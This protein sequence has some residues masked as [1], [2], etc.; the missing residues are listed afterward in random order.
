[1]KPS[2]ARVA[3]H[4]LRARTSPIRKA[5]EALVASSQTRYPED[6]PEEIEDALDDVVTGDVPGLVKTLVKAMSEGR[7][8]VL[9]GRTTSF[10][11][12]REDDESYTTITTSWTIDYP[13]S[14]TLQHGIQAKL[15]NVARQFQAHRTI[16]DHKLDPRAI[17]AFFEDRTVQAHIENQWLSSVKDAVDDMSEESL[18]ERAEEEAYNA[19]DTEV[20]VTEYDAD[21]EE[22]EHPEGP[23]LHFRLNLHFRGATVM[24]GELSGGTLRFRML[25]TYNVTMGDQAIPGDWKYDRL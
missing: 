20:E 2:P 10:S 13:T 15:A 4:H 8:K 18:L 16:H 21:G 25:A 11:D 14:V 19:T 7:G 24:S 17:A 12:A 6:A 23:E 22:T 1:M 5:V 9:L 3:F